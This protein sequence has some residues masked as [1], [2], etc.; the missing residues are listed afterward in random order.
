MKSLALYQKEGLKYCLSVQ[1]PS[2]FWSMRLRKT[3]VAIRYIKIQ[4]Q[5]PVLISAPYAAIWEWR[6]QLIDDGFSYLDIVMLIGTKKE[7]K[8]LL[9][10]SG[11]KRIFIINHEGFFS[12]PAI[13]QFSFNVVIF[14]EL[15]QLRNPKTKISQFYTK[16]FRNVNHRFGLTGTWISE[17]ELDIFQQLKFLDY[18][19]I[20]PYANYWQFRN[21]QFDEIKFNWVIRPSGSK[22]IAER[23]KKCSVKEYET[24]G[25]KDRITDIYRYVY[26]TKEVKKQ[27]NQLLKTFI[28]EDTKVQKST[29]FAGVTYC[30]MRQLLSGF[31]EDRL[32]NDSKIKEICRI[33][34][35]EQKDKQ[36]I[37]WAF[38]NEEVQSLANYFDCKY[39][40][41]SIKPEEREWIRQDFQRGIH[42]LLVL[43]SRCFT[44]G[45][46]FSSAQAEIYA[47]IPESGLVYNQSKRRIFDIYEKFSKPCYH[48]VTKDTLEETIVLALK[49][50][51]NC[52]T[53]IY[54][55][56]R[57]MKNV[58][59]SN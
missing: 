51:Q 45:A 31:I 11:N 58:Y 47:T 39:I 42:Q 27:Y 49:R 36:V 19:Y 13:G 3:I 48:I 18:S 32:L 20:H 40:N 4:N 12:L 8:N 30:W 41:G 14:D 59:K 21:A 15:H 16:N 1:H 44:H 54:D 57:R 29:I 5:Y 9:L 53:E 17:N 37:I 50:K 55:F 52:R 26:L 22:W 10:H 2:L 56:I 43:N 7:R 25:I 33:L 28:L 35:D 46:N 6:E 34:E 23:L 38:Y 24:V